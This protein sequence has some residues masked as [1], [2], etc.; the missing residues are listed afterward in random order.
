M[1]GNNRNPERVIRLDGVEIFT[2][3]FRVEN[4]G[5][6]ALQL[7]EAIRSRTANRCGGSAGSHFTDEI[8]ERF[9]YVRS[10]PATGEYRAGFCLVPDDRPFR[11]RDV[12]RTLERA[13]FPGSV[14]GLMALAAMEEGDSLLQRGKT[15]ATFDDL[16]LHDPREPRMPAHAYDSGS[17][18]RLRVMH[19]ILVERAY[20]GQ[21]VMMA[22]FQP[23]A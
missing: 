15:F 16:N 18:Y 20:L 19:D 22:G 21:D 1:D 9:K 14:G 11:P 17:T 3:R 8:R 4:P 2:F 5:V 6:G 13:G 23:H 10:L 7:I 12:A